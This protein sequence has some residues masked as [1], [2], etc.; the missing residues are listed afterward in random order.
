MKYKIS[1][2]VTVDFENNNMS[3]QSK[4]IVLEVSAPTL[5]KAIINVEYALKKYIELNPKNG[6]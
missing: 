6:W 4:N 5:E 3:P 2:P 1:I